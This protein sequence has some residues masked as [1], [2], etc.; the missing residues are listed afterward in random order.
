MLQW[1]KQETQTVIKGLLLLFFLLSSTRCA[2][3]FC[4]SFFYLL[5]VLLLFG[6]VQPADSYCVLELTV[7]NFWFLRCDKDDSFGK[8]KIKV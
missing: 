8:L 6:V 7:N 3:V 2:N 1:K 4:S 5:Y